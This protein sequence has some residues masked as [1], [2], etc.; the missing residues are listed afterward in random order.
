MSAQIRFGISQKIM[1]APA[2][3]AV[4]LAI[5]GL[6]SARNMLTI[7]SLVSSSAQSAASERE[8]QE[9]EAAAHALHASIYRSLAL[10]NMNQDKQAETLMQSQIESL[11]EMVRAIEADNAREHPYL[12][13]LR[14]YQGQVQQAFDAASS[15][16]NLGAM[17]MQSA[18]ASYD[19]LVVMVQGMTAASRLRSAK[20]H[21]EFDDTFS[22]MQYVQ[23][24]AL[25]AAVVLGLLI[26][27]LAGRR[28]AEPLRQIQS[29]LHAIEQTG[30]FG[31]RVQVKSHDEVGQTAQSVNALLSALQQGLQAAN[32]SMAALAEG[33]FSRVTDLSVRGDLA[34]MMAAINGTVDSMQQTMAGLDQVMAAMSQGQFSVR[35][36][37]QVRGAYRRTADQALGALHA[38]ERMLGDVGQ[39]MQQVAQG[40]LGVR[41]TAQGHGELETLKHNINTSLTSLGQALEAIKQNARQV[42]AAASESSQ[43]IGQIS[44]GAQNQTHAISQVATAV[45]QTA[46]SVAEVSRNTEVASQKSRQSVAVLRQGLTKIDA[47][48]EVVSSI[49]SNSE[50]INKITEV[51]ESIANKTNLL[52]LNAAIE[53]ARAGEHGKGFA[54]VADEVGKLA[55]NSAESSKEIA[56]LVQQAVR[57][58]AQA[59]AAVQ[60]V[61][62]DMSQI[63]MGS[64]ETDQ[65]LQRIASALEEQSTAVEQIKANLASV[66]SIARSNASASEEITASVLELSKIADATRQE[67]ARF[68][69]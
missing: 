6:Y 11:D 45:R 59:V 51:I 24:L 33:N 67:V 66:D 54:V 63:E 48:V 36:D 29:Q 39:V 57:D 65:M 20:A 50:K 58:T 7:D 61:S 18:N 3:I 64:Q 27:Y 2:I 26:A 38:L 14:E 16:V 12:P 60:A 62:A 56:Q 23:V 55:I 47:M 43:A 44:D 52:S 53:A 46:A 15:D 9:V 17:M 34:S 21:R 4:L 40:Q 28:I 8:A 69:V 19:E 42:A 49:A 37:L 31:L 68:Q 30:D 35:L 5:F 22:Q 13:K 25:V 1:V 32:R 41:V 10:I